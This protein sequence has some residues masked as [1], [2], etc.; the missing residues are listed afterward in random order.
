LREVVWGSEVSDQFE[1]LKLDYSRFDHVM[2]AVYD[3]LCQNPEMFPTIPGTKL[4]LLHLNDFVG[5]RFSGIPNLAMYFH[6]DDDRVYIV[7]AELI[8]SEE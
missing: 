6:Y 1:R 3:I 2:D 7:S 4:S 5:I 8:E